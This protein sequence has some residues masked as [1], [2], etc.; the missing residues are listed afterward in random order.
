M[1]SHKQMLDNNSQSMCLSQCW[2]H[3]VLSGD[4]FA[5]RPSSFS[6]V[7]HF[8]FQKKRKRKSK[9]CRHTRKHDKPSPQHSRKLFWLSAFLRAQLTYFFFLFVC[10]VNASLAGTSQ[11][12]HVV[13][14]KVFSH[15]EKTYYYFFKFVH[16]PR[17]G[18]WNW[19]LSPALRA[20]VVLLLL[21]SLLRQEPQQ[22][23]NSKYS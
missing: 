13:K 4:S 17:G 15:K 9:L 1:V 11:P 8:F 22:V 3:S 23:I 16:R 20:V 12:P 21:R 2:K 18:R 7:K 14:F 6:D 19:R 5:T 10:V